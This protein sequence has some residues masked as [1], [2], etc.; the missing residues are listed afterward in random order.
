[1]GMH[2]HRWLWITCGVL[3]AF[4]MPPALAATT[5]PLA[6]HTTLR[7]PAE[8]QKVILPETSIAAPALWSETITTATPGMPA[9]I[10]AW[11]GTDPA[12]SLNIE[13]SSDG[14]HYTHKVT[15]NENS[16][17]APSVLALS[18]NIIVL[19]W[20]GTDPHHSLNV[21]YDALGSRQKVT[22][23]D[24][25]DAPLGLTQFNGNIFLAWRGTDQQHL[26]NV[27]NM[28]PHGLTIGNA[29]TLTQYTSL[30]GPYLAP[31]MVH[32]HL[33]LTWTDTGLSHYLPNDQ[34]YINFLTSPDGL[35]WSTV[36]VAPPP[37]TSVA[38]P[39]LVALFPQPNN[40]ASYFWAWTGTD[41]LHSLNLATSATVN[42]WLAPITTFDEQCF[43]APALGY[44]DVQNNHILVAW[45][46]IDPL[47]HLNVA[48]FIV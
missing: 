9:S 22:L 42:G 41:P 20:V 39:S 13:T 8:D 3:A 25:S 43:G 7:Q 31:D 46:G 21:M 18:G 15:L 28:G 5:H 30:A 26:L 37:Q 1:M 6:A 47:H 10:L 27:R 33:L 23:L 14:L 44:V 38:G 40:F 17:L 24:N 4:C 35:N 34:P 45:A 19:A 32:H 29:V 16:N 36:L 2:W 12:H 11:T 48:T